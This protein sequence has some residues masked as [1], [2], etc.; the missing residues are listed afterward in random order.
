M[1]DA[2]A[3]A[4]EQKDRGLHRAGP[5]N[6]DVWDEQKAVTGRKPDEAPANST[7]SSRASEPVVVED[8]KQDPAEDKAVKPRSRRK[9]S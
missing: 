5:L 2:E 6:P 8:T 4:P 1:P 3:T 9:S 7:F